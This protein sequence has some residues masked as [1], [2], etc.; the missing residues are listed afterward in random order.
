LI[1]APN[2]DTDTD[3][4]GEDIIITENNADEVLA[5]INRLNR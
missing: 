5:T 2:V 4:K 1:D 3:K